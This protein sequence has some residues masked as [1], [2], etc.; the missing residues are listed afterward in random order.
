MGRGKG[1]SRLPVEQG[2]RHRAQSQDPKTTTPAKGRCLTDT[3]TQVPLYFILNLM[4]IIFRGSGAEEK[5][6]S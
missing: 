4:L 5:S 6:D 3:A 1:R 2:P